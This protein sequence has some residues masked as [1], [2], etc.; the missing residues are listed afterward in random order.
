MPEVRLPGA[1]IVV[2]LAALAFLPSWLF[3]QPS[4]DWSL[5]AWLLTAEVVLLTLGV[6]A[7]TGGRSW[8][9]H[10]A[11]PICF[12]FTAVP[13]PR[14]VEVPLTHRLMGVVAGVTVE[15]LT[16]AGVAAVQHGNVIEVQSGL[17]GIEE[18]CSGVRSLQAALMGALFLGSS[19]GLGG[20]VDCC[21]SGLA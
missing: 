14:V 3:A 21:S 6:V 1:G 10:F 20:A 9:W 16:I 7:W 2:G 8:L 5:C 4:P 12:I 15:I 11:F 18:A 19:F 13:C 17:L